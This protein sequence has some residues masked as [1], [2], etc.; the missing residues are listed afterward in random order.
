MKKKKTRFD[1][2]SKIK[3]K[4]FDYAMQALDREICRI[5]FTDKKHITDED[6]WREGLT[7][8]KKI[9]YWMLHNKNRK[10]VINAEN[11][12]RR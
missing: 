4:D 7:S 8:L 11:N 2:T 3:N 9:F 1:V 12:L 6:A 5:Q 10:V